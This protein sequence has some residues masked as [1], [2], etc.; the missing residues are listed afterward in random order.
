MDAKDWMFIEG[1]SCLQIV[2]VSPSKFLHRPYGFG[3]LTKL[4]LLLCH[5]RGN[6][7]P[8]LSRRL[9]LKMGIFLCLWDQQLYWN[10]YSIVL[11]EKYIRGLHDGNFPQKLNSL[12]PR[13]H[14]LYNLTYSAVS[15]IRSL[16]IWSNPK[17]L[18]FAAYPGIFPSRTWSNLSILQFFSPPICNLQLNHKRIPACATSI[19]SLEET[20]VIF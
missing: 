2:Q 9:Y 5:C 20:P 10:K 3:T 11:S 12:Y 17:Q 13:V 18:F 19:F 16:I 1:A 8:H 14:N 6:M 4:L 7:Q 15:A